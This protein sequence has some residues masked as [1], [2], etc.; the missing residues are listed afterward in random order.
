MGNTLRGGGTEE[1][2]SDISIIADDYYEAN[3]K[4]NESTQSS[5]AESGFYRAICE[6]VEKINHQHNNTQINVPTEKKLKEAFKAN[7]REGTGKLTKEE[8]GRC[9]QQVIREAGISGYGAKDSLIYIFGVPI[10][11]LLIKQSVMP[12]AVSNDYFIPGVTSATALVL[13]KLNKI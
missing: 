5:I 9:V 2:T 3:I 7:H 1:R 6:I 4:G 12:R 11:A 10:T 8:F 13:A